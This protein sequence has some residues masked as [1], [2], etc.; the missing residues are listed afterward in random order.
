MTKAASV[1]VPLYR[2]DYLY[3]HQQL[4]FVIKRLAIGTDHISETS[5]QLSISVSELLS[6]LGW[7]IY[8][9]HHTKEVK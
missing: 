7:K 9:K 5:K 8:F 2:D 1:E 4:M 6:I 3:R